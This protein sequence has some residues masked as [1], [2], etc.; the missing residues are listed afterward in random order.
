MADEKKVPMYT[1]KKQVCNRLDKD[2]NCV[3][4]NI[5][6]QH[7]DRADCPYFKGF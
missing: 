3:K 5:K 6:C 4:Y 2:A 1:T 7:P